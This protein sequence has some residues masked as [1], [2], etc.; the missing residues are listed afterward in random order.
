V[1]VV[2]GWLRVSVATAAYQIERA[3]HEDGRGDSVWDTFCRRPGVLRDGHT[4]DFAVDHYHGWPKRDLPV[5]FDCYQTWEPTCTVTEPRRPTS[6]LWGSI[7]R[8]RL[9]GSWPVLWAGIIPE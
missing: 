7:T 2:S 5:I 3:V 1:P 8:S 6:S 4:G 9:A